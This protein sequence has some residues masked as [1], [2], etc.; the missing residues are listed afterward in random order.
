[1]ENVMS[2]ANETVVVDTS[3]A[4]EA[5]VKK[6]RKHYNVSDKEF[7]KTW[8]ESNSAQEVADKLGMPKNIVLARSAVY[9]NGGVDLKVMPR[10]NPRKR[11]VAGLNELIA[12]VKKAD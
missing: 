7:C 1:M 9:R 12:S 3:V 10:V 4:P 8:E 11:D 6:T 5:K 2:E